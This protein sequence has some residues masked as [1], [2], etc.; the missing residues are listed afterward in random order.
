MKLISS[1]NTATLWLRVS[2]RKTRPRSTTTINEESHNWKRLI[3]I[4][5]L[6]HVSYNG[7]R[8]VTRNSPRWS[9]YFTQAATDITIKQHR[10]G[11]T[12][13]RSWCTRTHGRQHSAP[14]KCW[15]QYTALKYRFLVTLLTKPRSTL[16]SSNADIKV[17][18]HPSHK[19]SHKQT[20]VER[21][22]SGS[23]WSDS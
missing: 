13:F 7:D 15:Q 12:P 10:F 3:G 1:H 5:Q 22:H 21:R 23:W 11:S 18:G 6:T 20:L 8:D 14:R 9:N 4:R 17:P 16:H 2:A 19:T